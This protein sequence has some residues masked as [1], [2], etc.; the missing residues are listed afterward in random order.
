MET[1]WNRLTVK[2][3]A[4]AVSIMGPGSFVTKQD[5]WNQPN[6]FNLGFRHPRQQRLSFMTAQKPQ[7]LTDLQIITIN[8]P[9]LL[10]FKKA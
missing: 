9:E 6:Q 3:S 1:N 7:Q 10:F 4:G 2:R 5:Q 8:L